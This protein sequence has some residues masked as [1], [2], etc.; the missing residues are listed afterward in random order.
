LIR[1]SLTTMRNVAQQLLDYG[2]Y[3]SFSADDIMTSDEIRKYTST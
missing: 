3:D 1:A 2:P